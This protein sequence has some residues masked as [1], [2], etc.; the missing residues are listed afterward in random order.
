MMGARLMEGGS[1]FLRALRARDILEDLFFHSVCT[2]Q[3]RVAHWYPTLLS[4]AASLPK[5]TSFRY[6]GRVDSEQLHNLVLGN[7]L[8]NLSN[9]AFLNV[10]E[11][12][13]LPAV[14]G[15]RGAT[16]MGLVRAL[17]TRSVRLKKLDL[18]GSKPM[19]VRG[20][21]FQTVAEMLEGNTW[22]KELN[23]PFPDKFKSKDHQSVVLPVIQALAKNRRLTSLRFGVNGVRHPTIQLRSDLLAAIGNVLEHHNFSLRQLYFQTQGF[24]FALRSFHFYLSMNKFEDC[25]KL[26]DPSHQSTEADWIQTILNHSHDEDIVYFFLRKKPGLINPVRLSQCD[27]RLK[28][29]KRRGNVDARPAKRRKAAY[30]SLVRRGVQVK[31]EE[32]SET[33]PIEL[34]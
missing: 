30:W 11:L 23:L 28:T 1:G 15:N 33:N 17:Q 6:S 18:C 12:S 20:Q 3:N 22:L 21:F 2:T 8:G 24:F 29:R 9:C 25:R 27:I 13:G 26:R 7:L 34:D 16:A 10:L 14:I 31:P 32:G 5:L 19:N 4:V